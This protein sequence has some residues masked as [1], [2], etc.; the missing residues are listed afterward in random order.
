MF[1]VISVTGGA[2]LVG[3]ALAPYLLVRS[4]LVLVAISPAAHHVALAAASVDPVWLVTIA[5]VR[6]VIT[7][8]GAY[9]LGFLYGRGAL[10]WLEQRYARLARFVR[11]VE[12]LFTRWGVWLLVPAPTATVALLAGAA[13]S[14]LWAFLVAVTLGQGLWNAIT[15]YVGDAISLWTELLLGFLGEHVLESTL[16]CVAVVTLQQGLSRFL[17]RRRPST[18]AR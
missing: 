16:V 12:R 9:G 8:L 1:A 6:R 17:R 10:A 7:A 18:L 3:T 4:P 15:V 5:T 13:R 14:R 11:W 2:S